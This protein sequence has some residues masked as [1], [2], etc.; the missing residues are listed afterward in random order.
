MSLLD[1]FI[2]IM[3]LAALPFALLAFALIVFSGAAI[4]DILRGKK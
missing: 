4:F 2:S 1:I 3:M